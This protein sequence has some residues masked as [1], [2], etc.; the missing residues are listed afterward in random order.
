MKDVPAPTYEKVGLHWEDAQV[1]HYYILGNGV[2]DWVV[3]VDGVA[4]GLTDA[5]GEFADEVPSLGDHPEVGVV[6]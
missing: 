6:G 5:A 4:A 2:C 3:D 1:L